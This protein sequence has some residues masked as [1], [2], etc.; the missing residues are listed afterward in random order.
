MWLSGSGHRMWG[1]GRCLCGGLPCAHLR[2]CRIWRCTQC[3]FRS[4]G[5]PRIFQAEEISLVLNETARLAAANGEARRFLFARKFATTN[6]VDR[7]LHQLIARG[8]S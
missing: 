5:H 8:V 1:S 2:A 4:I 6:A 3:T 7:A